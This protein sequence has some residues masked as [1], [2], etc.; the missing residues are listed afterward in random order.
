[1]ISTIS[2]KS[3]T[4]SQESEHGSDGICWK[5]QLQNQ[6]EEDIDALRHI[7]EED[8]MKSAR[9]RQWPIRSGTEIVPCWSSAAYP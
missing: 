6:V 8:I 5:A 1:M 2:A 3:D 7:L 9:G 4:H